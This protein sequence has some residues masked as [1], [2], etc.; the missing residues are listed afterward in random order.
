[1]GATAA[2][3]LLMAHALAGA[4]A[5]VPPSPRGVLQWTAALPGTPARGCAVDDARVFQGVMR[6]VDKKERALLVAVD[7]ATGRVVWQR[8][9]GQGYPHAAPAV[10]GPLVVHGGFSGDVLALERTTGAERWRFKNGKGGLLSTPVVERTTAGERVWLGFIG[11]AVALDA[12]TGRE[13][14]RLPMAAGTQVLAVTDGRAFLHGM[15]ENS[16][17]AVDAA[18]GREL[19]R[20]RGPNIDRERNVHAGFQP[21]QVG[22]D[23]RSLYLPTNVAETWAVDVVTGKKRWGYEPAPGGGSFG[24]VLALGGTALFVSASDQKTSAV[25]RVDAATGAESWR[26]EL[27][28]IV[29]GVPVVA[30]DVVAVATGSA[31]LVA[32]G[33]RDGEPRFTV[34]TGASWWSACSAD[35]VIYLGHEPRQLSAVR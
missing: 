19:W 11:G 32:F 34:K 23:E 21:E 6:P 8:E 27:P 9:V 35:G 24:N 20:V 31:G 18:S 26:R 14:L 4:D 12:A 1:M 16:V 30:G 10:V 15:P 33:A 22:V 17:L 2:T 29:H 13:L 25:A 3:W 5:E 28:G 7:R